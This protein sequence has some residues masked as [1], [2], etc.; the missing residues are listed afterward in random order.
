MSFLWHNGVLQ[1]HTSD[2]MRTTF[3]IHIYLFIYLYPYGTQKFIALSTASLPVTPLLN[4]IIPVY[5]H[6]SSSFTIPLNV[7]SFV[8]S[9]ST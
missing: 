7:V 3:N 4:Q 1:V 6:T 2:E 5:T 8:P 9:T